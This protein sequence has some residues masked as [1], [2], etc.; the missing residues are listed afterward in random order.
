MDN[1]CSQPVPFYCTHNK[2]KN[3]PLLEMSIIVFMG[4]ASV[5]EGRKQERQ[6]Y[7]GTSFLFV[8]CLTRI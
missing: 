4:L 3:S 6:E 7:L 2:T 1:K 5:P 8:V